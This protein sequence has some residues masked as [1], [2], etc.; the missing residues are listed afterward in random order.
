MNPWQPIN[1][2]SPL[3]DYTPE[4]LDVYCTRL[5]EEL[6]ETEKQLAVMTLFALS[7]IF[8]DMGYKMAYKINNNQLTNK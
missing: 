6:S 3:L 7:M 5:A 2:L 4:Q 1:E 8:D